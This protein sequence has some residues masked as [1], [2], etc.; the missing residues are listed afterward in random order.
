MGWMLLGVFLTIVYFIGW[1][2]ILTGADG[3]SRAVRAY[4]AEREAFE[5]MFE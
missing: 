3:D 4:E 2:V 5:R 1:A